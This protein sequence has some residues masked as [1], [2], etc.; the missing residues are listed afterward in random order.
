MYILYLDESGITSESSNFVLAGLAVF[1]REIHW[2]SQ[3]ADQLQI[4][5]FPEET[6]TVH[7]H[8]TVLHTRD[9]NRVDP[10]WDRLNSAQRQALKNDIYDVI[11]MRRGVVFGCVIEKHLAE[12]RGIDPY[13]HAFEDLVSRFDMFMSRV[14]RIAAAEDKEEQRG[15]IVLAE[16]TYEKTLGLLAQRLK[17]EGTRWG[18]LHNVTDIPFFAPARDS[19]MLQYADFCANATYGRYERGLTRDFDKIA[20]KIDQEGSV[21]HG[22]AHLT[23]DSLCTCNA[24]FSRRGRQ[25]GMSSSIS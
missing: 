13:Q 18:L 9:G 11:R 22:L 24:C 4:K 7:F 10:P 25:Q 14:N 12:A 1:E 21:L 23:R 2:F 6:A 16:S 20:G 15:L 5:Y 17:K 8:A 3:D 19:R